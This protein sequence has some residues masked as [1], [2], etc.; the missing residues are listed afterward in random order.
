MKY[1]LRSLILLLITAGTAMAQPEVA[2]IFTSNMV[3]QRDVQV[4]VWGW[5]PPGERIN[6]TFNGNS[7]RGRAGKDAFA[8]ANFMDCL[9]A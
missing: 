6:V 8:D 9:K 5:A 7:Y 3:I 1:I 2:E 4:P